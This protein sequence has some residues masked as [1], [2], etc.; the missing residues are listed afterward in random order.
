MT[1]PDAALLESY[2]IRTRWFGGGL[3]GSDPSCTGESVTYSEPST[4]RMIA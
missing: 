4:A 3:I 2:L 1:A